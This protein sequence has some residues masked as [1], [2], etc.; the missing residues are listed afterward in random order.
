[1]CS[2][3][4]WRWKDST[5]WHSLS[6]SRGDH[7]SEETRKKGWVAP[8]HLQQVQLA[9]EGLYHVAL[10]P[11]L[12]VPHRHRCHLGLQLLRQ[13]LP[14]RAPPKPISLATSPTVYATIDGHPLCQAYL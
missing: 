14:P 10:L 8:C 13:P 3:C 1:M 4:S 5:I 7:I 6:S 9:L 12:L 2:R 11:Q